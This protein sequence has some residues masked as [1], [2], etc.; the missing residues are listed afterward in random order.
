MRMTVIVQGRLAFAAHRAA[1][2]RGGENGLQIMTVTQLAARLAGGFLHQVTGEELEFAVARALDAGGFEDIEIRPTSTRDDPR[3][4]S[5]VESDMERGLSSRRCAPG[6]GPDARSRTARGPRAR[7]SP[8]RRALAGCSPRRERA[9]MQWGSALLGPVSIAG[10]HFIEPVWHPL[11]HELCA[12]VPVVWIAPPGA[13]AAWFRGDVKTATG[14]T[15]TPVQVTCADSRHEVL[16]AFRCARALIASGQARPK[17]IAICGVTTDEWDEH[18]I[19]LTEETGLPVCFPHGRPCLGTADGQRCAA[20]A[21][22]L[23][24]GLSQARVR[25]LFLSQQA[26]ERRSTRCRATGCACRAAP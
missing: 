21:D 25:R 16:E 19:A 24:H 3:R 8:R 1:A 26:S 20:L 5:D 10:V 13:D 2:A 9:R 22:V 17:A 4:R 11:I 7:F 15:A 6:S 18:V 23:L 12:M 14:V